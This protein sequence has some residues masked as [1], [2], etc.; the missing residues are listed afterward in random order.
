MRYY[1][2]VPAILFLGCATPP[3]PSVQRE[4]ATVRAPLA[5]TWDSVVD[6]FADQN[7]PIRTLDRSSGLIIAEPIKVGRTTDKLADCGSD[8]GIPAVPTD[9]TYNVRVRGDSSTSMVKVTA[10]W[11]RVGAGRGLAGMSK[12]PVSEECG[13]TGIWEAQLERNIQ[14]RAEA[15]RP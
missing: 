13:S 11:V 14:A 5:K 7:I 9:V 4:F 10:R 1:L 8:M 6:V 3:A 2:L 15:G 12:E